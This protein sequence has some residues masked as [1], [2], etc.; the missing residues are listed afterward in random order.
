MNPDWRPGADTTMLAR[1]A[2]LLTA[3]RDFFGRRDFMEVTT[4][5]LTSAGVTDAHLDSLATRERPPR[6]LRT[7]PELAHKRLLAA[8]CGDIY[9]L[10]PAFRGGE[11]G[12]W[13]NP[14]FT[15]L[16]WYRLGMDDTE[17]AAET[18]ELLRH[19]GLRDWPVTHIGWRS[20]AGCT[21]GLDPLALDDAA[22]RARFPEAPADLDRSDLLDW[23]MSFRIQP[24]LPDHTLTVVSGFPAEQAALARLD[25]DDPATA[26]RFEVFAGRIELAN[27]Y[28]ELT[29]PAE[30]RVRFAADNRR[31][32]ERGRPD[33]TPDDRFLAALEAGLPACAG[34]A[35]GV[36]RLLAVLVGADR[37]DAVTAFGW[38]RC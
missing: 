25:P 17:L 15:L 22:L 13:H 23:I 32:R 1:R 4:P 29:D 34:V 11:D 8:G 7:S 12:R 18:V 35:L 30:Q 26:R 36:D 2:R 28:H 6:F 3:I 5:I 37:L 24:A 16:E 9:E 19:A 20:L 38:K 27:G 31:R 14:E 10:G 21:L 33:M